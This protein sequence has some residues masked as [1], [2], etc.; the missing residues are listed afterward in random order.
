MLKA[1]PIADFVS[2]AADRDSGISGSSLALGLSVEVEV[3]V[4][5]EVRARST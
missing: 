1:H 2:P 4:E 5:V 3:E